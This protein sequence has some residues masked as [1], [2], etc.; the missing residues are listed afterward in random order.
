MP[1]DWARVREEF[2]SLTQWVFLNTATYGQM[3]RCAT[4]AVAAHFARRDELAC[5][6]FLAWFDDADRIRASVGKLI[7]CEASDIAFANNAATALAWVF[8]GLSWQPGDQVV[9]LSGEF[10]NNLYAPAAMQDRGVEFVE[11]DWEHFYETVTSRTRLVLMSTANYSTGFLPP[12]M[13]ISEF[14]RSRG[15]LFCVDGTQTLGA[16]R[17]DVQQVRPDM[18]A[19]H[20]YKW[21]LSPN[22]AGFAYISPE[23]RARLRPS[24]V[25]WRSDQG[26]RNVANLSHGAPL[27][28]ADAEK[29]EG[30]MLNFPSLYG[31]GASID[32]ML[33]LGPEEIE[34]RVLGLAEECAQILECAGAQILHR[35]S[36]ILAARFPDADAVQLAGRLKEQRI[37]VSARHRSLRVSVHFYND[38]HDLL[39]LAAALR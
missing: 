17:F 20:G 15:V 26:W 11:T 27:F 18:L 9:A 12:L 31:M 22:G 39:A 33:Q 36:P 38:G 37:L 3:P 13:E 25:G 6:D 2:P 7:H 19:V 24:V 29:F 32:M 28:C 35:G 34:K 5:S 23:F 10:P 16:L 4:N 1:P 8:N 14:L 30:G 21:L